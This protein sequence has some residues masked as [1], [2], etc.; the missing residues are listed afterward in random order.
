MHAMVASR[1]ATA[2][3]FAVAIAIAAVS[4]SVP[5]RADDGERTPAASG[6]TPAVDGNGKRVLL[7]RVVAV[8]N[9]EI[10]LQ[11]DLERRLLPLAASLDDI[12]DERERERRRRALAQQVLDDLVNERLVL[13]AAKEAKLE[14]SEREVDNALA[15]IKKQNNLDDA[16]LAKALAMQGYTMSS[17]REDVRR[18]I[19]RMRAINVLVRPKVS[20]T[21][22]DVR[23]AYDARS[24]RSGAVKRVH[25]HHVLIAVP[26]KVS[27]TQLAQAKAR[28]AEVI[29]KARS[30]V[31]FADLAREYSDDDATKADGGDLG[32]IERGSLPTEWE[33][34][35]FSMSKGEVR[36]PISG[37]NGL[38]VFYVSDLEQVEQ[39]PFDEVKEQ[40]R[41]ELFRRE[42][43][44]KTT[45]W[46]AELRN[47][48][49]VDIKL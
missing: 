39:K 44:R 31:P 41:G 42:M 28:A 43:D 24:R 19:L 48:A 7:D 38:H 33:A 40:I 27:A 46:L 25:L 15:E 2:A 47:K 1:L 13:E 18:Q 30:G 37:P 34:I 36:G 9:D 11:S 23:A 6:T 4:A 20:V 29:D 21:D 17:Y 8:V 26:P 32:W 22:E 10:I 14:V 3:R 5:A 49:Y 45:E 12:R 35:V 16:G